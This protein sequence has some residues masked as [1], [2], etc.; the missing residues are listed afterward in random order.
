MKF[1][2]LKSVGH[3]IADSLASGC[4][5]LIGDYFQD[6]FGEAAKSPDGFIEIDFLTGTVSH[7]VASEKLTG[8][9]KELAEALPE[10]CRSHEIDIE[11]IETLKARFLVAD[12]GPRFIV[13]VA[14]KS[15]RSAVDEFA[16]MPGKR[17][18]ELDP[19]GRVRR[20]PSQLRHTDDGQTAP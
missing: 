17:V 16:G 4:S 1:G 7:G 12:D 8:A 9:A 6:V 2:A 3:N 10:L 5:L 14:D 18:R 19:Q 15:G 20:K 11:A 13:T